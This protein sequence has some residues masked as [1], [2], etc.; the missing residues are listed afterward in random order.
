MTPLHY[1]RASGL[2]EVVRLHRQFM[3]ADVVDVEEDDAMWVVSLGH[4]P[5]GFA[6]ARYLGRG[7]VYI[8]RMAVSRRVGRRGVQR[9]LIRLIEQWARTRGDVTVQTYVKPDNF[10]SLANFIRC[11][12]RGYRPRSNAYAG[13][14]VIY[15][16]RHLEGQWKKSK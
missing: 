8:P 14:T 12:Y 4:L 3:S 10:R 6:T 7:I 9:R 1:R 2:D 5:V 15:L 11:G 16:Q 13:K